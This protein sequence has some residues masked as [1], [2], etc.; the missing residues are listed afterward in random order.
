MAKQQTAFESRLGKIGLW[1]EKK[2]A[3]P[4]LKLANQRHVSALRA[5]LIRI[6]P[7]IIVGSVPLILTNLPIAALAEFMS[8]YNGALNTL[9]AMSFNFLSLYLA[10]AIGAE[11]ARTYKLEVTTVSIIA[12]AGFLITVAPVNLANGTLPTGHL[13]ST[14]M[15]SAI[16]VGIITAE[17]IRFMR[18]RNL[19]IKMPAGVPENIAASFSSMIPMAVLL[20]FFW[21]LRVVL[22]F[23]LT[24]F[25]NRIISPLLIAADTWWAVL[26]ASLLLTLLWF[27]GVHGGSLT[28][29]G[30]L[31]PF[32]LSNI[33]ANAA[34]HQ[35]GEALPHIFTEPFVF[36]YGMPTG[37]GITL[38]LI[39]FWWNSKSNKLKKIARMSLG[40]GIFNINEP[41]N[42]GAPVL[43]NPLMF[44][45]FVFGTTLLGMMYGFFITKL[46]WVTAPFI[47]VPWTTPP[48]IQPYLATG[49]DWRA[50]VAQLILFVVVAAI[51]YPF[52]KVW[53]KRCVQEELEAS[54]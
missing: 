26:I 46:G 22:H 53:E 15:I 34:A 9:F 35:A 19:T 30:V 48:L 29:Q 43:L 6:I 44:I 40:P 7:L 41:V 2:I 17:V 1:V 3:P 38:P 31:Y 47:Q 10:I 4:M 5:A 16:I 13:G 54:Q 52:A 23:D 49:G 37:V 51:W 25:L 21:L 32:L 12:A 45:P 39:I 33:A 8:P 18:D 24:V 20:V 27:V 14:G 50:P 28:V 36:T 11:M 42:F